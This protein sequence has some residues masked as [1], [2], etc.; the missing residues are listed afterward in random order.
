MSRSAGKSAPKLA[1]FLAHTETSYHHFAPD[2]AQ[3]FRAELCAP[4][5]NTHSTPPRRPAGPPV[6]ALVLDSPECPAC[7]RSLKWYD[8]HRRKLPWR[9]DPPPYNGSTA[10]AAEACGTAAKQ[11]KISVFFAKPKGKAQAKTGT[12]A[13][14]AAAAA[15]GGAH[16][17]VTAYGTWVSEIML[18]QTRVETVV[19]YY[20]KWMER[21]PTP[22][23]LAAATP[24][25]VNAAWAGLGYYR[26]ARLL[27][28]GAQMVAGLPHN[29]EMPRTVEALGKIPGIGP[30]TAGAIASIAFGVPVPLVDG[31][32]LR[33]LSRLKAVA[34]TP[35]TPSFKT[36]LAWE[37][38]GQLVDPA[39]PG[40]LNQALMELGATLCTPAQ[41]AVPP[42][43]MPF[44]EVAEL[45][46]EL[47]HLTAATQ[48]AFAAATT[49]GAAPSA[50]PRHLCRISCVWLPHWACCSRAGGGCCACAAGLA[51]MVAGLQAA[52]SVGAFPRK[53]WAQLCN[54]SDTC[55]AGRG[56]WGETIGG[57]EAVST[58]S[59]E[60][61]T[62]EG[63]AGCRYH[64]L[65]PGCRQ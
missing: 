56:C 3:R 37:L 22:A 9:G 35:A 6:L 13:A 64:Q 53:V 50:S 25:E 58:K 12:A 51:E 42:A 7:V 41:L 49:S 65:Y 23:A 39:R 29:G 10:G 5:L 20:V 16:R 24:D 30:Y 31:N 47:G 15:T 26:R 48:L 19:P 33:V 59:S 11:R 8:V 55:R 14:A 62:A 32:V 43:L 57:R 17:P 2:E 4:N 1:Q 60:E 34:A 61:G 36:A 46:D 27:H 18:Q 28:Q 38:A 52:T 54:A 45:A 44:F 21:W 40:D 63:A